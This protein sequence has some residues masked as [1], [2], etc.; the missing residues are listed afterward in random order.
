M[1][2]AKISAIYLTSRL[3]WDA[4]SATSFP[5]C[6]HKDNITQTGSEYVKL[7]NVLKKELVTITGCSLPCFYTE[8]KLFGGNPRG[9]DTGDLKVEI[10]YAE[11]DAVEEREAYVYDLVSFVSEEGGALGLFLGFSFLTCWEVLEIIIKGFFRKKN[12]ILK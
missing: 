10:C 6:R 1:L 2:R 12:L 11:T 5:I 4:W 9:V 7:M 3:P 8:Y